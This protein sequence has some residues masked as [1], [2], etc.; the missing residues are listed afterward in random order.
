LKID[1]GG[2][3]ASILYDKHDYFNFAHFQ[4]PIYMYIYVATPQYRLLC[5]RSVLYSG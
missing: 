4:I 5:M 2:K 3:L 1:A